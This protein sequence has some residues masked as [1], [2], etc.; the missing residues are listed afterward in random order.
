MLSWYST[1]QTRNQI[2]VRNLS[3]LTSPPLA[4]SLA[5][6]QAAVWCHEIGRLGG[7]L[8]FFTA[9][10][11]GCVRECK[12]GTTTR[13]ALQ[14]WISHMQSAEWLSKSTFF[15]FFFFLKSTKKL[16]NLWAS[17]NGESTID[18][19]TFRFLNTFH[20]NWRIHPLEMNIFHGT[21][22]SKL[23]FFVLWNPTSSTN[24]T[25]K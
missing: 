8:P 5:V 17:R 7:S 22:G 25:M 13:T 4:P 20:L 10:A 1:S 19:D 3:L 6:L 23:A 15:F 21:T 2:L 9:G 11:T 14:A 18:S 16:H 24:H 12:L